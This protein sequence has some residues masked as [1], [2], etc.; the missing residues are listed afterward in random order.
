MANTESIERRVF[1]EQLPM[2]DSNSSVRTAHP[3]KER[4]PRKHLL[5]R[6]AGFIDFELFRP[7]LDSAIIRRNRTRK[8]G[9]PNWDCV[10]MFKILVAQATENLS[11]DEM[12][13]K[14]REH[15]AVFARFL[16]LRA[17]ARVP[18]CTTIW[19][20]RNALSKN[21]TASRCFKE[22]N[23]AIASSGIMDSTRIIVDSTFVD[24]PRQHNTREENQTI[25]NGN[26]PELWKKTD[27]A[28][29]HKIRQKDVDARWAK[30]NNETHYGY[31]NHVK[32]HSESKLISDFAVTAASVHDSQTIVE[33]IRDTDKE[34][35]GDS[36]Y[37]GADLHEEIKKKSPSISIKINEKG[38]RNHPLS[39]TQ[40]KSNKE[41]S[42]VR[43]RVE[44]IFGY[45]SKAMR[46]LFVRCI[47]ISR[48]RCAIAIRNL[49]HNMWRYELLAGDRGLKP[50]TAAEFAKVY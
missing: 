23:S 9:R 49:V 27:S 45:M 39:E 8:G 5:D 33:L 6:I 46:G 1:V 34:L 25:K 29:T 47:G 12:E 38:Y 31:K 10:L 41:N 16:G 4:R 26:V 48:A 7:I 42:R 30:K 37:V 2:W 13:W 21:D 14:M 19:R 36:A 44:H 32:A 3:K 24:A 40:K 35:Y 50:I 20:F 18:D 22:L 43:A 28:S 15:W 17:G 11:D